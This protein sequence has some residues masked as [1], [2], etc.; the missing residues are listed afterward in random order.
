MGDV[1][2]AVLRAVAHTINRTGNSGMTPSARPP[3]EIG[4]RCTPSHMLAMAPHA[5]VMSLLAISN[6]SSVT[7]AMMPN[8]TTPGPNATLTRSR[9]GRAPAA[10]SSA[11]ADTLFTLRAHARP[12]AGTPG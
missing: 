12:D 10:R 9:A 4:T 1:A 8:A 11:L 5:P 2:R 7:A 6:W 3:I